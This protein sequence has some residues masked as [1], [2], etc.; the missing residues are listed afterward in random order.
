MANIVSKISA[1]YNFA[2]VLSYN[3]SY[4]F[5]IGARGLGKTYGAEKDAINDAIKTGIKDGFDNCDQFIYLRRYKE[6]LQMS[7][8]T[9]FAAVGVEFPDWD[10]KINGFEAQISPIGDRD[11]KRRVWKTIGFFIALSVAQ[12][13]KS[14]AFPRVK[15]IIYDEFIIEKGVTHY[16]P[17]EAVAFNNFFSTVD[18][19]KDKTRVLF[20]ANS[21]VITN[22]YF[23]H[24]DIDPSK[25]NAKGFLRKNKLRDGRHFLICHFPDSELFRNEVYDTD[26]GQF[27]E[28]SEYADYAVG[29]KFADAHTG[30][31]NPKTYKA[32]YIFTIEANSGKF[33][34]WY[35]INTNKYHCE[36]KLPKVQDIVVLNPERM[37][38]DKRLMTWS[39]KGLSMLRGAYNHARVNFDKPQTRN[40]FLEIF[41]R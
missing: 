41:K 36:S 40:A 3:A 10:F 13:Y 23:I 18:R 34:V 38:D 12:K 16:L 25:A 11:K 1:Y 24:Y 7:R 32:R 9:F 37:S 17:N 4:N 5:I 14:V 33:S 20:L 39:D 28:D 6:E 2:E 22:P 15:K 26:F 31:V 29:N 35:D 19:Y 30:L 27:I 8:D 21:V